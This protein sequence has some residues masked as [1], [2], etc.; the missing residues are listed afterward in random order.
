MKLRP[1]GKELASAY[2][3][4]NPEK[5]DAVL[6][7]LSLRSGHAG[8]ANPGLT[9]LLELKLKFENGPNFKDSVPTKKIK[10]LENTVGE[11][12]NPQTSLYFHGGEKMSMPY[13]SAVR[14]GDKYQGRI[15]LGTRAKIISEPVPAKIRLVEKPAQYV[16]PEKSVM[17]PIIQMGD[18]R[19]RAIPFSLAEEASKFRSGG[20]ECGGKLTPELVASYMKK[21]GIEVGYVGGKPIIPKFFEDAIIVSN[22]SATRYI[23]RKIA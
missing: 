1:M 9:G 5:L 21:A 13:A 12:S 18:F 4:G 6:E 19:E 17:A 8:N 23:P 14:R 3:S 10:N 16:A 15:D 2:Y 20:V 7:K 11:P 22:K